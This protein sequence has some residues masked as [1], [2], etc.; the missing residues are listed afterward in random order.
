LAGLDR[1]FS[2]WLSD[3]F[4]D[5][6]GCRSRLFDSLVE[7]LSVFFDLTLNVL[8]EGVHHLVHGGLDCS[9]LCLFVL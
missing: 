1:L 4:G 2:Y 7:S 9:R 3:G 8:I 5:G 6:L